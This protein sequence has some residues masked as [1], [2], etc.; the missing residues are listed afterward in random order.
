MPLSFPGFE[1]PGGCGAGFQPAADLQSA[2]PGGLQTRRRIQSGPTS[3]GALSASRK[4][5]RHCVLVRAASALPPT[6][7]ERRPTRV[8]TSLDPARWERAPRLPPNTPS[9]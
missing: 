2:R 9:H 3:A 4:T 1:P 8:E 7:C 5:K 6:P